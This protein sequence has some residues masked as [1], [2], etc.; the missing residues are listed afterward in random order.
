[1]S[2][3]DVDPGETAWLAITNFKDRHGRSTTVG[4]NLFQLTKTIQVHVASS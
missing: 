2:A 1:M 4:M 3:Y